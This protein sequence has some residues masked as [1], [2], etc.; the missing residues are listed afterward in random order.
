MTASS[1]L[2]NNGE[3]AVLK[4]ERKIKAAGQLWAQQA[5]VGRKHYQLNSTYYDSIYGKSL[6]WRRA[7]LCTTEIKYGINRRGYGSLGLPVLSAFIWPGRG[8]VGI[9]KP[10]LGKH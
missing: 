6:E 8:G 1:T 7:R 9:R 3:H 10:V 2:S 5:V 4:G